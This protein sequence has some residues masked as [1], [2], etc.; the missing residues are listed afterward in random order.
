MTSLRRLLRFWV[1]A[2]LVFQA[3][4]LSALMPYDCCAAHRRAASDKLQECHEQAGEK[5]S[6]DA[7]C[8]MR[9]SCSGP[10]AALVRLLSEPGVLDGLPVLP[11]DLAAP[12]AARPSHDTPIRRLTAPDPPPPRA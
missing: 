5:R 12:S 2:W 3:V 4:S 9:G 6:P 8:A 10:V 11:A 7:T 1:A